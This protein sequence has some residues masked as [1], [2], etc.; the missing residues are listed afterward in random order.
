MLA[1]AVGDAGPAGA[2][3]A[4][5]TGSVIPQP[6]RLDRSELKP[7]CRPFRSSPFLR[8][9]DVPPDFGL[10]NSPSA[11]VG[12]NGNTDADGGGGKSFDGSCPDLMGF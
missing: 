9:I 1:A 5:G 2:V 4:D 11:S 6:R 12:H 7:G 10:R 8:A 3:E